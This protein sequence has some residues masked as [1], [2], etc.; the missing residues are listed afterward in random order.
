M[1][2]HQQL[3]LAFVWGLAVSISALAIAWRV[4]RWI[5]HR[6]GRHV[7]ATWWRDRRVARAQARLEEEVLK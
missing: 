4:R 2:A 3:G 6:Y 7:L 5:R 1:S